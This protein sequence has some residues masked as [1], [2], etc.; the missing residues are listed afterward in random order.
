MKNTLTP[1]AASADAVLDA[2]NNVICIAIDATDAAR[3]VLA[4]NNHSRLVEALAMVT[5]ALEDSTYIQQERK[6]P[7]LVAN[8]LLLDLMTA[9]QPPHTT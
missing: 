8:A 3:I 7:L 1:W 4:V 6:T 5:D 2:D 9:S